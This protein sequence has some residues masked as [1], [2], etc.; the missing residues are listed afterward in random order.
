MN[1]ANMR[2]LRDKHARG[3]KF[4]N[5][6]ERSCEVYVK[7][8]Q[9]QQPFSI[10][11]EKRASKPLELIHSDVCG[12]MEETSIGDSRYFALFIVDYSRKLSI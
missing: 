7:G 3:L 9:T 10:K 1:R 2:I 4:N 11:N 12:P 8:K 6:D 5:P